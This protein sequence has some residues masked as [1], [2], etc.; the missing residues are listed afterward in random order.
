[1]EIHQLEYIVAVEKFKSFSL[2]AEEI[3]LSQST[4]SHQIKKLEEELGVQIFER[5]TRSI[6]PT[7]AGAQF[8]IFA[9]KILGEIK[10]ARQIMVE[11]NNLEKG[12]LVIGTLPNIGYIGLTSLIATFHKNYPGIQL[13]LRDAN[14]DQLVKWLQTSDIDAALLTHTFNQDHYKLINFYPLFEDEFVLIVSKTHPLANRKKINLAEAS[15]EKFLSTKASQGVRNLV[16]RACRDAGFEPDIIFESDNLETICGLVAEG[17][18]VA[19]LSTRVVQYLPRP[20]LAILRLSKKIKRTTALAIPCET[21]T[22]SVVTVF[23]DF[24]F[25]WIQTV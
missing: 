8:L 25:Q 3:C 19:L 22:P 9:K 14:S 15:E 5:T 10:R 17:L 11:F 24:T 21:L 7:P 18:G 13:E 12:K 6:Q 16:V 4:L 2:A 20:N 23:R 1:M